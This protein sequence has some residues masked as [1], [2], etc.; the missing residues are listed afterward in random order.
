ME[1]NKINKYHEWLA[2]QAN[3]YLSKGIVTAVTEEIANKPCLMVELNGYE[4]K[5]T[6]S[7]AS[8]LYELTEGVKTETQCLTEVL[9]ITEQAAARIPNLTKDTYFARITE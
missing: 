6:I 2:T 8:I 9:K 3:N 5:A 7:L 1:H 4:P